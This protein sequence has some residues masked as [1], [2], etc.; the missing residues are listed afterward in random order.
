MALRWV[1]VADLEGTHRDE[2]FFS[3]DTAMSA[4][5]IVGLFTRRWSI[6]VTFEEVRAHLGFETPRQRVKAPGLR[7][8]PCIL[9]LFTVVRVTFAAHARRH[10][11]H[12]ATTAWYIKTDITF[13]DALVTVR[14]LL[15]TQTV[16]SRSRYAT[17]YTRLPRL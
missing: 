13:S 7:T 10:R 2:C 9:G 8:A 12:P 5:Q 4:K 17:E 14:C 11:V 16:L 6:E 1:Y 15:W 3:T